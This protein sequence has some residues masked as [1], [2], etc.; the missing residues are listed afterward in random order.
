MT[1]GALARVTL[2][3]TS[4]VRP[5]P[6]KEGAMMLCWQTAHPSIHQAAT[7]QQ[8]AATVTQ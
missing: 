1:V 8:A 6:P 4:Q 5:C 7:T 2:S 3:E